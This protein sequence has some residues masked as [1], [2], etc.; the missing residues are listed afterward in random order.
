MAPLI[1]ITGN[2]SSGMCTMLEGYFA[3]V[4]HAGGSPVIVP[5]Y[6]DEVLMESL[7]VMVTRLVK[8]FIHI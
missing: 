8:L 2:Y 1:A 7:L 3:S 4:V 5:P 6:A